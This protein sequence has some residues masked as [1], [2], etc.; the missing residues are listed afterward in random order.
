MDYDQP[1]ASVDSSRP[2]DSTSSDT[3]APTPSTASSDPFTYF[4]NLNT[5]QLGP[6]I[7]FQAPPG[8]S[9][10]LQAPSSATLQTLPEDIESSPTTVKPKMAAANNMHN[11]TTLIKR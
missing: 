5:F 2:D 1:V 9:S 3:Y 8:S 4:G 11:L 10:T 6:G 7:S